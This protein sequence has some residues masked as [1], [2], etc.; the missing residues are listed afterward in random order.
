MRQRDAGRES[1]QHAPECTHRMITA[2]LFCFYRWQR[3]ESHTHTLSLDAVQ[4]TDGERDAGDDDEEGEKVSRK[5]REER[6]GNH[7]ETGVLIF[8]A[9]SSAR[10]SLTTSS[11]LEFTGINCSIM[12][13][14]QTHKQA[15]SERMRM[16]CICCRQC[17]SVLFFLLFLRFF[18]FF[19]FV[20]RRS[21]APYAVKGRS[22]SVIL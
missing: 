17:L 11:L 16:Q 18:F 12:T 22:Q 5:R 13:H 2:A 6:E 1:Y 8:H 15:V 4:A 7:H 14:R 9:G 10:A 20:V 3:Q 19:F 21:A